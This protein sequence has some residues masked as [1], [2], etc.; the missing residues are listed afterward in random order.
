MSL[1]NSYDDEYYRAGMDFIQRMTQFSDILSLEHNPDRLRTLI[2]LYIKEIR[3]MENGN[4][5]IIP[6]EPKSSTK[7]TKWCAHKDSNLGPN[8]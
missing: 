1:E 8:D 3:L 4:F 5:K 7:E 2:P 6:K